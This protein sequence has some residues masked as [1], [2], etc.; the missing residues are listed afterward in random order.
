MKETR[1][2]RYHARQTGESAGRDREGKR[3]TCAGGEITAEMTKEK[4]EE[5]ITRGHS[6]GKLEYGFLERTGTPPDIHRR[7]MR[8]PLEEN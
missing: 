1:H 4:G 7:R 2:V 8:H 5:R 3:D 6:S